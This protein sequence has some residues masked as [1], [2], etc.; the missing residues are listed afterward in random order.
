MFVEDADGERLDLAEGDGL[1]T[2]RAFQT[3]VKAANAC[4]EAEHAQWDTHRRQ[5]QRR[6]ALFMGGP[7]GTCRCARMGAHYTTPA[8][9]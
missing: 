2:A 1:E 5:R 4:E 7:V 9:H 3:E 6:L 8:N